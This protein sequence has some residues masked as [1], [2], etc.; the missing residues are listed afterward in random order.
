MGKSNNHVSLTGNLTRDPELRDAGGTPVCKLGLATSKIY[1]DRE[2]NKQEKTQFHNIVVW[3]KLGEICAKYLKKGN[4]AQVEGVLEYREYEK[5][6][7]K[8]NVTEII[9]ID[10]IFQ[11]GGNGAAPAGGNLPP[12]ADIPF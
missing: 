6:G 10:V 9:A 2:G 11:G 7:V 3:S 4:L 12:E 1:K 8:H 5:D